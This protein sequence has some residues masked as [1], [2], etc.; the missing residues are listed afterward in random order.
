MPRVPRLRVRDL[1]AA[2]LVLAAL[3]LGL[4]VLQDARAGH[5]AAPGAA[6]GAVVP[7]LS[8]PAPAPRDL[9]PYGGLGTW[10]DGL[11][12]GRAYQASGS[13]PAITVADVDAMAAAGV[14]TLYVQAARDDSRSPEGIVERATVAQL[15]LR[16]HRRGL[17]VV[18]WYLPRFRGVDVDLANLE[19]MA[20]FTVLG[21][22]FDGIAVDIEYTD[23]VPDVAERNARLVELSRAY[24]AARPQEAVGAIVLP[25]VQTEVVN[26]RLWPDFP[27][28]AIA[29]LYDVWL[30]M[31]YWTFRSGDYA[32]GY[33]Y[34]EEST[35]RL[36]TDLGDQRA[37]VH[38]IGGIGDALTAS[39]L[40]GFVRSLVETGSVGGS[41]YDWATLS[42]ASRRQL[43][44]AFGSGPAASLPAPP[45]LGG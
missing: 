44:E 36:R 14:K 11:D 29:P 35:R 40:D 24:R 38:G 16:A 17:K 22:R 42:E 26:P 41:I 9:A 3:V 28:P 12:Y 30:P 18:A 32:D 45:L 31:S 37:V 2:V 6:V 39:Q 21:H 23:D 15:L 43:A 8:A 5:D 34:N 1:P 13:S 20:A 19:R 27:W 33:S 10:V 7:A 25:P 4:V